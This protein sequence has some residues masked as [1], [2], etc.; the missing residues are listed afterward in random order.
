MIIA[1]QKNIIEIKANSK[2]IAK[3]ITGY[4]IGH[5]FPIFKKNKEFFKIF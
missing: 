3:I 4:K 2:I 1:I 5:I